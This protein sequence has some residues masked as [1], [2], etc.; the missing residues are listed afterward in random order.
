M[1]SSQF[2]PIAVLTLYQNRIGEGLEHAGP[3]GVLS[4]KPYKIKINLAE[5]APSSGHAELGAEA[6]SYVRELGKRI[7]RG[8]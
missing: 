7:M 3:H 1:D 6:A 8:C 4:L 5:G 2:G